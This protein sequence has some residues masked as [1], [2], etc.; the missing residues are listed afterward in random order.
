VVIPKKDTGQIR[1]CGDFT[2]LNKSVKRAHF[3][4]PKV[5]VTLANL[6]N[7]IKIFQS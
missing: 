2:Q 3:P 1:I 4:I 7:S 6:K 5:R